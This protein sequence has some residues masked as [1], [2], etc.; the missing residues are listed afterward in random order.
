MG[1]KGLTWEIPGLGGLVLQL[2]H[3]LLLQRLQRGHGRR[4]HA[5][6]ALPLHSHLLQQPCTSGAAPSDTA[7]QLTP[8]WH[9]DFV[10]HLKEHLA[11]PLHSHLLQQ[12]CMGGSAF[13]PCFPAHPHLAPGPW[14]ASEGE[15]HFP[16]D[17]KSP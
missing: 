9:R 7:S 14:K 10:W 16:S 5:H 12:P 3:E 6:L 8:A 13:K 4:L 2:R 1:R 17:P 15:P 11:L